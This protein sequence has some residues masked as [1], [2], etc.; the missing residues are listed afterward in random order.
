LKT[1]GATDTATAR[2]GET[3]HE[4]R[5]FAA[6]RHRGFRPFFF[7]IAAAM[8]GDFIEH[9]I[10]YWVLCREF[11]RPA[12]AGFAIVSLWRL[13]LLFSV[14]SGA[15]ADRFDPRRIIQAAMLL[16]MGASIAWGFLFLTDALEMWHAMVLLVLH[17]AAGVL[18]NPS[19]QLMLHDIVGP[20]QLQSAVRLTATARLLGIVAGQA[21]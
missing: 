13:Y 9:V 16:F 7:F 12:R 17:G 2:T 21:V 14:W 8:T 3:A 4:P 1:P 11:E 18:W 19:V 15:L 20:A 6:L 10:S 5:A